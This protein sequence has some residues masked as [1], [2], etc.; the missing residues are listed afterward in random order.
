MFWR[1]M[2]F[3]CYKPVS[4]VF[5]WCIV[6]PI[7]PSSDLIPGEEM[8][9]APPSDKVYTIN[10]AKCLRHWHKNFY[11]IMYFTGDWLESFSSIYHMSFIVSVFLN[12]KIMFGQT[13]CDII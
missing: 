12:S 3:T 7:T 4:R 8:S 6:K 10:V 11:L 2:E 9:Q 5:M 1:S 13:E